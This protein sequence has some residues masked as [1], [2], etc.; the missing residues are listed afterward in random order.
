MKE[1]ITFFCFYLFFLFSPMVKAD[2]GDNNTFTPSNSEE[3]E[4][5][6]DASAESTDKNNFSKSDLFSKQGFA[7]DN[8]IMDAGDGD[9]PPPPPPIPLDGGLSLLLIGGIGIGLRKLFKN[10][11]H[12]D[13]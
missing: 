1:K 8:Q 13:K 5:T 12:A 6:Y 9:G 10:R 4:M 3:E 2:F 11:F 7:D